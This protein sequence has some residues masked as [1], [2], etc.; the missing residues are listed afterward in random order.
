MP[1]RPWEMS[2][3]WQMARRC[4]AC[5]E[6]VQQEGRHRRLG[7]FVAHHRCIVFCG[8]CGEV[9]EDPPIGSAYTVVAHNGHPVHLT[10]KEQ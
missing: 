2:Q 5:G 8:T 3:P 1:N 6:R 10:C 9:I 7:P 4:A